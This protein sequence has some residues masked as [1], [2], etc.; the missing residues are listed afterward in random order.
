MHLWV[1]DTPSKQYIVH[2][3][4]AARPHQPHQHL[5]VAI[6]GPLVRIC[7]QTV[8]WHQHLQKAIQ[9]DHF[10]LQQP[11]WL[12]GLLLGIFMSFV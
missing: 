9:V 1:C 4:H 11:W 2:C 10:W 3:N 12:D 7:M 6:S 5:V 8:P